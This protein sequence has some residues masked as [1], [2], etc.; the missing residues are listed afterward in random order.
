MEIMEHLTENNHGQAQVAGVDNAGLSSQKGETCFTIKHL[1][2]F[3][4]VKPHTIRIWEQRFDFLSPQRTEASRRFYTAEQVTLFLQVCLL[5]QNGYRLSRIGAMKPDEIHA[6]IAGINGSQKYTRIVF[7]LIGSMAAMD[8]TH[9]SMV[10]DECVYRWGI[11]ETIKFVVIPFSEKVGLFDS[12]EKKTYSQNLFLVLES[13]KQKIYLA[14]ESATSAVIP[15]RRMTVLLF[16]SGASVEL[17]LLYLH[18]LIK[19]E[20]YATIYL[21]KH[22]SFDELDLICKKKA[23]DYIVTHL[24]GNHR[25]N[26][27]GDFIKCLPG[28]LPGTHVLS[29][30]RSL[31]SNINVHYYRHENNFADIITSLNHFRS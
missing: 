27:L 19:K 31:P 7:D 17:P 8:I 9:F 6:I 29:A 24:Q 2:S 10:L 14:I 12:P 15:G 22:F 18:Y 11:H 4:G 16:L 28:Y 23:P 3:S 25:E 5:K 21:G 26:D 13:I 30:G 1:A 20:G